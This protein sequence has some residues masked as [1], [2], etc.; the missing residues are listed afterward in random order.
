MPIPKVILK[1]FLQ[2]YMNFLKKEVAIFSVSP[3][4]QRPE[5]ALLYLF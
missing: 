1:E 4:M 3:S 2:E 5:Y